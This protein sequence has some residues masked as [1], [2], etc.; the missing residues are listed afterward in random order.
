M[1]KAIIKKVSRNDNDPQVDMVVTYIDEDKS[2]QVERV[3]TFPADADLTNEK[4]EQAI[5]STGQ[6]Y[7][8][9]LADTIVKED[10]IR[11]EFQGKEFEIN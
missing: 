8:Q 10:A 7:K 2:F 11:K 9:G 3:F 6:E 1:L 5:I 4:V